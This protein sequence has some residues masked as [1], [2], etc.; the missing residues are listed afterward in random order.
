MFSTLLNTW[1]LAGTPQAHLC[2]FAR[3]PMLTCGNIRIPAMS[4]FICTI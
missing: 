2:P 3:K 1:M 4:I